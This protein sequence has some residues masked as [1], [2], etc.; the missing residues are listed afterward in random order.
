MNARIGSLLVLAA[1][2]TTAGYQ[3]AQAAG[4]KQ[5]KSYRTMLTIKG[6][7]CA[8]CAKKVT[9]KLK[10]V[11]G[12]GKITIDPKKGLGFIEPKNVK[13]PPSPRAQWEAVEKAGFKTL[14]LAGPFGKFNKKPRF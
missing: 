10:Q 9:A 4:E 7:H 8:S 11:K 3:A 6:M 12:V 1:L 14:R 2:L 13:Q 5:Q